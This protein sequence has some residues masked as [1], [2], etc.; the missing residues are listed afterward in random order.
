MN[1]L[2]LALV[3]LLVLFSGQAAARSDQEAVAQV[4]ADWYVELR[5]REDVRLYA[6]LAPMGMILPERCPDRCG[7]QPRMLKYKAGERFADFLAARAEKFSYEIE[8]ARVETT[9]ARVDVWERGW[10]YAWA[11]RQTY[12]SAASAMFIL[13]KRE[14]QGWK[15]LVY[16]SQSSAI[17]PKHKDEPLPDLSPK[18]P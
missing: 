18:D 2:R 11:A 3:G 10:T 7:P 1:G 16:R 13:E 5:K 6:M 17:H 12:Q 14:G 8:N 4:I 9:L 15:V